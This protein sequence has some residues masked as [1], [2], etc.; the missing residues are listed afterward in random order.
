MLVRHTGPYDKV[1]L[2]SSQCISTG[3]CTCFPTLASALQHIIALRNHSALFQSA[4]IN[5]LNSNVQLMHA[6]YAGF[7]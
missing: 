3:S 4:C 5:V 6:A 7:N 1:A 2:A